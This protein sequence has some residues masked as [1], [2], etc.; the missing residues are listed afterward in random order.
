MTQKDLVQFWQEGADEAWKTVQALM[1]SK[2][3]LHALFFCHLALEKM[4]KAKYAA[5]QK[6][7]P[8]PTHHLTWLAQQANVSL[9]KEE[10]TQLSQI[11]KFNIAGRYEDD[12][13]ALAKKATPAYTEEWISITKKLLSSLQS[14]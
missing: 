14:Q 6:K 5:T 1:T 11:M 9:E 10:L 4:L 2:R 13:N 7:I 8:P 3:Y 12:K